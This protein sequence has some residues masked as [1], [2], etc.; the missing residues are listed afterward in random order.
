MKFSVS[1]FLHLNLAY[2]VESH[3]AGLAGESEVR[4][5]DFV[6]IFLFGFETAFEEGEEVA[7]RGRRFL[8]SSNSLQLVVGRIIETEA[9]SVDFVEVSFVETETWPVDF[10]KV[11]LLVE[12][13]TGS[14]DFIEVSFVKSETRSVYLIKIPFR[15]SETV[16]EK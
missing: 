12:T 3:M 2:E 13:E 6:K 8:T 15:R 10:I 9:W 16:P 7:V 5:V 4:P 14:V 11:S 1:R